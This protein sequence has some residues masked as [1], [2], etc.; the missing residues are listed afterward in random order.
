VTADVPGT[1]LG[2]GDL[3][4]VLAEV[5]GWDA[6]HAA[7]AVV[8]PTGLRA[9][10]GDDRHRF[11]WASVTKIV[12]ALTVLVAAERGLVDLDEPAGPP[13]STVRHLLAHASGLVFDGS[14]TLAVPGTRRIYSNT[15][16]DLLGAL[17]AE[18]TGAPFEAALESFVLG[19]LGMTGTRLV[20]RP[21]Q[22]LHGPLA[23]L[24]ALAHELLRP[25]L[26]GPATFAAATSVAF[27]GLI[28]LLPGVGRFD[29]LD[30]GLGVELH[31]GKQ[32]HWMGE[33]NSPAAFGHFGGSGT[34]VWVDPVAE[35]ALALLTDREFGPWALG[36][37]PGF[38]DRVLAATAR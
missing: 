5:D 31:D 32:P 3:D 13:G 4:V 23:D 19:P 26:L 1:L 11:R 25:S 12:T 22:G 7:V 10:H 8:D 2:V 20:E 9:T 30:W 27:P 38:S 14:A 34:F 21:S 29:P 16:F 24:A 6:A 18:R 33:R 15:G 37:W 36:A 35:V 17:L 28:G